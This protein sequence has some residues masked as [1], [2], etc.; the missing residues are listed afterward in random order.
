M[1]HARAKTQPSTARVRVKRFRERGCYDRH[2]VYRILDASILCQI[3][4]LFDGAPVVVPTLYWRTGAYL[5]FHGSNGSRMLRS[6]EGNE[7]CFSTTQL[8]GLVLTRSAFH[9]SAN[10]R[11]VTVFG[12]PTRVTALKD[13]VIHLRHFMEKLVPDRWDALRPIKQKEIQ[14]TTILRLPIKE[15]SAKV[16]KGGPMEDPK[17]VHWSVWAGVIPLRV[18]VGLPQPDPNTIDSRIEAPSL[19][20]SIRL[21]ES[22][23]I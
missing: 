10:Y 7:I 9:H 22:F 15:Y 19:A 11:S 20:R 8:D 4:F 18:E 13:K 2:T 23:A 17:D 16:R 6:V 1:R 21:A 14:A 5:Y 12:R 3:G